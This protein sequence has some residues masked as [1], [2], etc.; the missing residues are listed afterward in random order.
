MLCTQC[1]AQG[2]RKITY[3]IDR[4]TSWPIHD[5]PGRRQ[6]A[7]PRAAIQRQLIASGELKNGRHCEMGGPIQ[8]AVL[9]V[10]SGRGRLSV[11]RIA[12]ALGQGGH[13]PDPSKARPDKCDHAMQS[14][15]NAMRWD[16]E[17]YVREYDLNLYMIVR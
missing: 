8:E 9:F 14:L 4:P 1:E 12:D 10:R 3:F 13:A 6:V 16:E 17:N 11:S 5:D 15:K 7:L 2:F